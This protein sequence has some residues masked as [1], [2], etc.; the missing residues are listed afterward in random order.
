MPVGKAAR[1]G[2]RLATA[3]DPSSQLTPVDWLNLTP[4]TEAQKASVQK[5]A[6]VGRVTASGTVLRGVALEGSFHSVQ[7]RPAR[8]LE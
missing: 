6:G 7:Q 3:K 5:V 8:T 4:G 2:L 1:L